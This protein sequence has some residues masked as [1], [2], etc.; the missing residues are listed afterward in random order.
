MARGFEQ[1]GFGEAA[2]FERAAANASLVAELDSE[3]ATLEGYLFPDTYALARRAGA[4]AVVSAM[5]DR[6]RRSFGAEL[7]DDAARRKMSLREVVTLASLIEKE[8]AAPDERPLVSAVYHNRLAR[9]MP[10][11]AD[12]TVIYA[13]MRA[14]RWRGNLTRDD[15]QMNS[16]YNTYRF[17]GLPPGPIASPGLRSLEAA[18]RPAEVPYLYFVSRND[19]THAFAETLAE[20]N[21]NVREWQVEYFRKNR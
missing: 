20:H 12:P 21:R 6:F 9:R 7:R 5:V 8:T 16:P 14:G 2:A 19:G 10:L 1:A 18:V 15:L 4:D 3:A 17:G 11:Q 13:L